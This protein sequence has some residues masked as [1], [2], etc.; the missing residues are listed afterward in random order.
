MTNTGLPKP[1][2]RLQ[3]VDSF[4]GFAI[5]A[6]ILVN[7]IAYF[8]VTP[9]F[10]QHAKGATITFA[11]LVAPFFLF[12]LGMMYRKSVMRRLSKDSRAIT[13]FHVVR[14]YS[15]LLAL[16]VFGGSLAK[17]QF[18]LDWGILQAIGLAGIIALPFIELP[19]LFRA[20]AVAVILLVYQFLI[21]S[22]WG[23]QILVAEHGG[24]LAAISWATIILLATIAGDYL[25]PTALTETL[26]KVLLFSAICLAIG[27]ALQT[28]VPISKANVSPSYV[29]IATGLS[30]FVYSSFLFL[31][32]V[33][34]V[35]VPFLQVL[36]RNALLIFLV[37]YVLVRFGHKLLAS[38]SSYIMVT[39]GAIVTFTICALLA[40]WLD[41]KKWYL[42]L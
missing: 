10:L 26:K 37:H 6:M 22:T 42:K 19:S 23:E 17:M 3:S 7:F 31:N 36:G 18:T 1:N 24:P 32:D 9:A 4:R 15:I 34:K 13:Y 35:S 20:L 30:A 29:L 27:F 28:F 33:V 11:D 16:G 41:K 14:R 21:L 39:I 38:S 12:A 8:E 25:K 5:I 40:W 2:T